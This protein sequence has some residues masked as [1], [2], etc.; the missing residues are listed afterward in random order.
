MGRLHERVIGQDEAIEAVSNA[1]H[2]SRA[3]ERTGEATAA[4]QA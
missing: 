1:L 2:R 3:F 4:V